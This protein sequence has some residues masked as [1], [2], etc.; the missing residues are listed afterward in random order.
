MQMILL[1]VLVKK[2]KG[3]LTQEMKI[4]EQS[5]RK[6][7]MLSWTAQVSFWKGLAHVGQLGYNPA[8][9]SRAR[10][11]RKWNNGSKLKEGRFTLD[12]RKKQFMIRMA[13]HW[14]RLC[15]EVM[16]A[17]SREIFEAKLDGA[18][19]NPIRLMMSLLMAGAKRPLKVPF[20]PKHSMILNNWVGSCE[21]FTLREAPECR[22]Q[23]DKGTKCTN[24]RPHTKWGPVR[25]HPQ[26]WLGTDPAIL[27]CELLMEQGP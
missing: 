17:P 26:L 25:C 6:T 14:H 16:A 9:F 10:C 24:V 3:T 2:K 19:S 22:C 4:E 13:K 27:L 7:P 1:M 15:G 20:T 18:L 12:L 21:E 11:N 5:S 8:G 23:C